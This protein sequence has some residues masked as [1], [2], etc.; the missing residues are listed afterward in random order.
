MVEGERWRDLARLFDAPGGPKYCWCMVWRE[1]GPNRGQLTND[2]RKALLAQ[3]VQ[4][5]VPI[6]LLA[7][8]DGEPVGW[9]SIA[10]RETLL[11]GSLK[12]APAEPGDVVWSIVCFYTPRKRRKAGMGRA[13][14]D[15]AVLEATARGAT[16]IES[17]PVD[18]DS[19]SYRFM[20]FVSMYHAAGFEEVGRAG[21]RRHVMRLTVGGGPGLPRS[22]GVSSAEAPWVSARL[23]DILAALPG[24]SA[25]YPFGPA[26]QVWK[27]G[28]KM[29]ALVGEDLAPVTV[30]LKCDPDLALALRARYPDHVRAGYH[31]NKRHWNT[32]T[33][34]LDSAL[35]EEWVAHSYDLVVASLPKR[36]RQQLQP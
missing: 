1:A 35:L 29:F 24:A 33:T 9:C 6:G 20:G 32:V 21:T 18:A 8:L 3:R 7:Y 34:D 19:P 23:L 17:Y 15:A 30:S 26:A 25:S 31:L 5:N 13:L 10:P 14:L 2:D 27:V 11:E 22:E 4:G 36:V 16:V 28:G 12:G